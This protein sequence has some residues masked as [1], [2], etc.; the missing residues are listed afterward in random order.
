MD[1]MKEYTMIFTVEFTQVFTGELREPVGKI[2]ADFMKNLHDEIGLKPKKTF[3]KMTVT[4]WQLFEQER[5]EQ[6]D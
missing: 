1:S 6:H 3:D 5:G 4:N 2:K